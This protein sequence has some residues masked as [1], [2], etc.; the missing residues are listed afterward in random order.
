MHEEKEAYRQLCDHLYK[1]GMIKQADD[2]SF[3]AVEDP[4]ERQ[5]IRSESKRK[6]QQEINDQSQPAHQPEFEQQLLNDG[7]GQMED[8]QWYMELNR[9]RSQH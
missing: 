9:Q 3:I 7:E 1:D 5:S 2:G 4:M 8:L 6:L